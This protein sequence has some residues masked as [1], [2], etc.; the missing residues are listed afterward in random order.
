MTPDWDARPTT[1]PYAVFG[2][3]AVAKFVRIRQERPGDS[4]SHT[5]YRET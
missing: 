5:S 4:G 2:E 1:V 3:P